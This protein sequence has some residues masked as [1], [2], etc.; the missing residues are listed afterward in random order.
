MT[1]LENNLYVFALRSDTL[2]WNND[3]TSSETRLEEKFGI[4]DDAFQSMLLPPSV[5]SFKSNSISFPSRIVALLSCEASLAVCISAFGS[6][7]RFLPEP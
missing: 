6:R 4:L 1:S 2:S 7:T 3:T 5:Y